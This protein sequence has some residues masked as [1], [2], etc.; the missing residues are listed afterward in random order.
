MLVAVPTFQDRVAPAFDFC[1]KITL[2][3]LDTRGCRLIATKRAPHG[4]PGGRVAA[5][6]ELGT[7]M[8]LCGAIGVPVVEELQSRGILVRSGLSGD[9]VEVVAALACGALDEAR[10]QMPGGT[11]TKVGEASPTGGGG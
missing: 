6:R 10:F 11:G 3:R 9:V 8:L 5:L 2:W 7:Q 1:Q 4:G